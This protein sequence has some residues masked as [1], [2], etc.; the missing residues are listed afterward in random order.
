MR[1]L[2]STILVLVVTRA[3]GQSGNLYFDHIGIKEGL[4]DNMIYNIVQDDGGYLWFPTKNGVVRYDGYQ[5][6]TYYPAANSDN[7]VSSLYF[8]AIQHQLW[9]SC[10]GEGLFMYNRKKDIFERYAVSGRN[11]LQSTIMASDTSGNLWSY[12]ESFGGGKLAVFNPDTKRFQYFG[13]KEKGNS[14]INAERYF[15]VQRASDG[16][17]WITTDNGLY[18]YNGTGK[19]LTRYFATPVITEKKRIYFIYEPP[20]QPGTFWIQT[21][22]NKQQPVYDFFGWDFKRNKIIQS[23][24]AKPGYKSDFGAISFPFEDSKRRLWFATDSGLFK[25]NTRE[26]RFIK[27]ISRAQFNYPLF[28]IIEQKNGH[29]LL[30]SFNALLDFDP[31]SYQFQRCSLNEMRPGSLAGSGAP[32]C[33]M[34]NTGIPW[35]T[36]STTGVN[37][38]NKQ[39]SAFTITQSDP[40]IQRHHLVAAISALGVQT[41]GVLHNNNEIYSSAPAGNQLKRVYKTPSAENILSD[42][43]LAPGDTLFFASSKGLRIYDLSTGMSQLYPYRWG[44]T[45]LEIKTGV[46]QIYRD[47]EG[48]VWLLSDEF[49][50]CAFNPVLKE[51]NAYHDSFGI[52]KGKKREAVSL[53]TAQPRTL[54]E[55]ADGNLWLGTDQRGLHRFDRAHHQFISYYTYANRGIISTISLYEDRQ[56]RF[57]VGTDNLGLFLFDRKRGICSAVYDKK[58]SLLDNVIPAIAEDARGNIWLVSPNGLTR[59]NAKTL[60]LRN[61]FFDEISPGF[62]LNFQELAEIITGTRTLSFKLVYPKNSFISASGSRFALSGKTGTAIFDPVDLED[63]VP[64]IVHVEQVLYND[65]RGKEN[66]FSQLIPYGKHL[67]TLPYN[68]NRIRFQYIGIQFNDPQAITYAYKLDGYDNHWVPAGHDRGVTYNNL[69]AGTYTFQVKAANAS[70]VWSKTGDSFTIIINAPWWLRWW[71]WLLYCALFAGTAYGIAM[72]RSRRLKR[73]NRLLEE[74]VALRTHQLNEQQEEIVTQRDQLAESLKELQ[75]T[76]AQLIQREKMASLG[77][78]TAGIAHEI[79]NP[80]NFVNN[81]SDVSAELV[82]EMDVELDKGDIAEAKAISTDIKE[83]LVKIRHHGKRADAIV[84]GMLEHSRTSSGKK[85]PT[86]LNVLADEYLRLAYHGLRGK[87]KSFNAELVTNFEANLPKVNVVP[88]DIGRVLLNVI[89][90]AFYATQQKSKT[91]GPDFKPVVEVST[92]HQDDWVVVSVKD[93]GN[94]LPESIKDKVMQPFFTTKPTGEGTGLGLSL[95]YDMV[96]KG[97]NGTLDIIS[98]EGEGAE[99]IVKLPLN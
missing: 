63:A 23:G 66:S 30:A 35:V 43:L 97:H 79:Q 18:R 85:E 94:G 58:K 93:N 91:A 99:F 48:L 76:Q 19:P 31:Q 56:R 46:R 45:Q 86:N 84:K 82:D 21:E 54:L 28:Q 3:F 26:M 7:N 88:Q 6:K 50:V 32:F 44:N 67:L 9:V 89:N 5:Y 59:L 4:P 77:E 87:D 22:Q 11:L 15:D 25:F 53:E 8:D 65:T 33:F 47:K 34:D 17:I 72:F 24:K 68:Q 37:R 74:K 38:L 57:W 41:K 27:C 98:Q 61:F 13:N 14:F 49:G 36:F 1:K 71:A 92:A 2:L 39:K 40:E 42:V 78:L 70:G 29:F 10:L 90:N 51:F 75:S 83:N 12:I 64:P 52:A 69:S 80:L 96:V 16:H 62:A 55:D 95:S 20:S 60:A 81:F 73:E